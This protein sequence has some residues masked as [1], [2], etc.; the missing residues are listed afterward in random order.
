MTKRQGQKGDPRDKCVHP[1]HRMSEWRDA[2]ISTPNSDR[3]GK[4]RKC[5][6]CGAEQTSTVTGTRS[7][8]TLQHLCLASSNN[9]PH[10]RRVFQ[11]PTTTAEYELRLTRR[12]RDYEKLTKAEKE[13]EDMRLGLLG[14]NLSKLVVSKR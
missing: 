3:F 11:A 4:R 9:L 10:P 8:D 14:L 5:L 12:R 7:G 2:I 1:S 13:H 6:S